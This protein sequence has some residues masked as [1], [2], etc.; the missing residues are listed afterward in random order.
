MTMKTF[1]VALTLLVA[2]CEP[3]VA[4]E[5]PKKKATP[6]PEPPPTAMLIIKG[7]HESLERDCGQNMPKVDIEELKKLTIPP[8]D[9]ELA[10]SL[11][12]DVGT[13]AQQ[14]AS[15][16]EAPMT[17]TCSADCSWCPVKWYWCIENAGACAGGDNTAC[18]KLG[19]CGPT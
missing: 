12:T 7:F 3:E 11:L 8:E 14:C 4:V 16:Y 18:C 17:E 13:F 5:A 9:Q 1:A 2:G 6:A 10:D 15:D 19:P